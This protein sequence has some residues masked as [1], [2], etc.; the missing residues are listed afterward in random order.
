MNS[1]RKNIQR[2]SQQESFLISPTVNN[3]NKSFESEIK[4]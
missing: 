2:Y 4:A 3:S 1:F